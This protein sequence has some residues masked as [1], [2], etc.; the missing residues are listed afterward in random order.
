MNRQSSDYTGLDTRGYVAISQPRTSERQALHGERGCRLPAESGPQR[1]QEPPCRAARPRPLP[2]APSAG[3]AASTGLGS[4][5]SRAPSPSRRSHI[6]LTLCL[7]PGAPSTSGRG[8][9]RPSLTPEPSRC[10]HSDPRSWAPCPLWPLWGRGQPGLGCGLAPQHRV[11]H[12]GPQWGAPVFGPS[13]LS[14]GAS[15]L[16]GCRHGGHTVGGGLGFR[17]AP[18]SA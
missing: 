14:E 5:H 15:L 8:G 16:S 2:S 11:P 13:V 18:A 9:T 12:A 1:R 10:L 7:T 17:G 3:E 6:P 4:S